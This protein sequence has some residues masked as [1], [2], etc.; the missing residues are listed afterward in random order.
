MA[1]KTD[2]PEP[3][4]EGRVVHVIRAPYDLY[5]GRENARVGL[6][7]S[8]WA[9][10]FRIGRDGDRQTVLARFEEELRRGS[11]SHLLPRLRELEGL[12][13]ACW[14]APKGG[15][16]HHDPLVCHAQILLKV[17][18]EL[19]A[20]RPAYRVVRE[21]HPTFDT[22]VVERRVLA[23]GLSRTVADRR[24][25]ELDEEARSSGA[26]AI[27]SVETEFG[28]SGMKEAAGDLWETPADLRVITTNG[29]VKATGSH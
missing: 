26:L 23:G 10:P 7:G 22:S 5:V 24:V 28:A 12:T 19:A 4:V 18:A 9:N 1:A 15:V 14:C 6:P 25:R 16:G 20:R 17:L 27:H 13:L 3:R 11:L 29:D 21:T 2:G 8:D